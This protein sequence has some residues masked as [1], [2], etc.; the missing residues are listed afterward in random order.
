MKIFDNWG[1]QKEDVTLDQP[2]GISFKLHADE[3]GVVDGAQNGENDEWT[4]LEFVLEDD[5]QGIV[6]VTVSGVSNLGSFAAATNAEVFLQLTVPPLP[7]P[8]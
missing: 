4:M 7:R 3:L 8:A 5:D 6:T 2:A 1:N